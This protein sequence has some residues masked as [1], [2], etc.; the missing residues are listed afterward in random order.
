MGAMVTG[1]E[2]QTNAIATGRL[3]RTQSAIIAAIAI[4]PGTGRKARKTP[5]KKAIETE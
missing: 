2:I 4:C 3:Q 1:F 5:T